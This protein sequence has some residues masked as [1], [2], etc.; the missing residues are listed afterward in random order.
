MIGWPAAVGDRRRPAEPR[1]MR[2]SGRAHYPPMSLLS[3][4]YAAVRKAGHTRW[5]ARVTPLIVPIDGAI[6]RLSKGRLVALGNRGLPGLLLTTT[7]RK[8]GQ[9]RTHPLL[10]M[11][12]GDGYVVVGSNWGRDHHPAWA[13]NLV[14]NPEAI[15]TIGGKTIR[16]RATHARGAERDRLWK[17]ALAT[18]P[19]WT[20][21]EER[22]AVR[23]IRVFRLAPHDS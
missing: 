17:L 5:F 3:P 7:G 19:A 21:Y 11:R 22:A 10:Y 6:G 12:D 20:T 9:P 16:V 1:D 15:V 8:T 2:G 14:A 23:E 4:L 18:W 13:L